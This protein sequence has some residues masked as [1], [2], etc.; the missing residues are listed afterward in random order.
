MPDER[1]TKGSAPERTRWSIPK[2]FDIISD[3]AEHTGEWYAIQSYNA[4]FPTTGNSVNG[5]DKDM[6]ALNGELP[7]GDITYG[8]FSKIT[9][10]GGKVKAYK[11]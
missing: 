9:L 8:L 1:T 4:S 6:S 10:T 11:G 7:Y 5:A 3:T 2:D